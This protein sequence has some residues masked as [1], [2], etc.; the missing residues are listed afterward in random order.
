MLNREK[1]VEFYEIYLTMAG[2]L[3]DAGFPVFCYFSTEYDHNGRIQFYT[4]NEDDIPVIVATVYC[5][6]SGG[7]YLKTSYP[8]WCEDD[9]LRLKELLTK[10]LKLDVE[11]LSVMTEVENQDTRIKVEYKVSKL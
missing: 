10:K 9:W 2:Q 6:I 3:R 11:T 8:A 5:D 7:I 4:V 1:A